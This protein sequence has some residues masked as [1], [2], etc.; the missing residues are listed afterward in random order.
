MDPIVGLEK[1]IEALELQVLPTEDHSKILNKI[2]AITSLLMQTQKMITSALSCREAITSML[3]P[4]VTINDYLNSTDNNCEVEVE[5]KRRYLLELYPELKNTVQSI[6]TFESLLPFLGSINTSRVVEFSEKLGELVL[7]N[8]KLYGECRDITEN[9]LVA[10]Q[11]YNDISSS[12]QIL[13]TQWDNTV[14]NLEL[15]LQPKCLNEQ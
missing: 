2:E 3:Q 9:V 10:L 11:Q 8:G 5:A 4:L 13:L 14:L 6:G 12:I 7:D 1:Q 15:A